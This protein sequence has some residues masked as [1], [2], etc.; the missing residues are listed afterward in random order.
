MNEL[1][2]ETKKIASDVNHLLIQV[3][4]ELEEIYYFSKEVLSHPDHYNTDIKKMDI[5]DGGKYKYFENTFYYNP[6]DDG[7]CIIFAT[8][9]IP[10]DVHVKKTM[11]LLENI[12]PK[13]K[14]LL[15]NNP[16]IVQAWTN[17]FKSAIACG[18]P[19][20]DLV[21]II[22][23]KLDLNKPDW[24]QLINKKNNPK[25]E[26]IWFDKGEPSISQIG[27][28]LLLARLTPIYINDTLIAT[29]NVSIKLSRINENIFNK[30]KFMVMF[31]S[32]KLFLLGASKRTIDT[33][34]L[35]YLNYNYL[36]QL[37]GNPKLAE[38]FKLSY[39]KQNPDLIAL[40]ENIE[41]LPNF[42]VKIRG[43]KYFIS[44]EKIP[45]I[46]AYIIGLVEI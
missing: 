26:T 40:M 29:S 1:I 10:V 2:N 22:P 33:L 35:K 21:S 41:F 44:V 5:E 25:R 31:V 12:C 28:G 34:Q 3:E 43:K 19:Y 15:Q 32:K 37:K 24:A 45:S 23:L 14:D 16:Y 46:G 13:M 38:E 20:N 4:E 6:K 17:H 30:S 27:H 7:N 11:R 42:N 39:E 8:G 18:Y 9:F 36:E